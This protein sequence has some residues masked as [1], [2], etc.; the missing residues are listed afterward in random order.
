MEHHPLLPLTSPPLRN[1]TGLGL[2]GGLLR[3]R[4]SPGLGRLG[5]NAVTVVRE[6]GGGGGHQTERYCPS[7]PWW[8]ASHSDTGLVT[9]ASDTDTAGTLPQSLLADT[10]L[11]NYPSVSKAALLLLSSLDTEAARG[12]GKDL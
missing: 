1:R 7:G 4:N 9:P 11:G 8:P 2:D 5:E 6:G 3:E 12:Q 10:G